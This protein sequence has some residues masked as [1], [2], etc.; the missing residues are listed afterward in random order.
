MGPGP[1]REEEGTKRVMHATTAQPSFVKDATNDTRGPIIIDLAA[2]RHMTNRRIS[3]GYKRLRPWQP[4]TLGDGHLVWATGTGILDVETV[5]DGRQLSI[6]LHECLFVPD[7]QCTL[8]SVRVATNRHGR[9]IDFKD[10][11]I[12]LEDQAGFVLIRGTSTGVVPTSWTLHRHWWRQRRRHLRPS[13]PRR[14]NHRTCTNGS[15]GWQI[16]RTSYI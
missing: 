9:L 7:L 8:F 12:Y 1:Q 16:R 11:H 2:S 5:M 13:Q 6:S 10:D 14:T 3:R 4:V 15:T